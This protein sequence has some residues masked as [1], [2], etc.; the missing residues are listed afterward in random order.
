[1]LF[2][3]SLL[4]IVINL[5]TLYLKGC[6]AGEMIVSDWKDLNITYVA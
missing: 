5:C 4:V 3:V 2:V 1:M 6:T